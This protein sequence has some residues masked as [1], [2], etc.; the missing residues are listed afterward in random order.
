MWQDSCQTRRSFVRNH[1]TVKAKKKT[2]RRE[3]EVKSHPRSTI[4]SGCPFHSN[5]N[6]YLRQCSLGKSLND[7]ASVLT[8]QSPIEFW[9]TLKA[10]RK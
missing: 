1:I 6:M 7:F 2:Q 5:R 9:D 3:R 4:T 10:K 8:P